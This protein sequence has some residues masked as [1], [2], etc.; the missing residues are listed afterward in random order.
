M[1]QYFSMGTSSVQS[2]VLTPFFLTVSV[3]CI[4]IYNK[5]L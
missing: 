1:F 4:N 5:L 2:E 3:M